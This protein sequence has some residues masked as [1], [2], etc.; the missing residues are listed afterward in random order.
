MNE[1]LISLFI[2]TSVVLFS[3]SI[4]FLLIIFT[5]FNIHKEMSLEC[6][7]HNELIYKINF[8]QFL[9]MFYDVEWEM[10]MKYPSSYF[11][12]RGL[13]KKDYIHA[14]IVIFNYKHYM[15]DFLSF[16]KFSYFIYN[17]SK[18]N[19]Q[20]VISDMRMKKIKSVLDSKISVFNESL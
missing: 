19:M 7:Q 11:N 2:A 20:N 17:N 18:K 9:E 6:L 13:R 16:I 1:S 14:S 8:K 3:F 10:D 15:F 5:N 12:Y 4:A